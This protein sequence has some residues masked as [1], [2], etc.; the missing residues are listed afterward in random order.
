MSFYAVKLKNG[1]IYVRIDNIERTFAN[2]KKAKQYVSKM[3]GADKAKLIDK[4]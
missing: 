4:L 2:K 3:L 1:K